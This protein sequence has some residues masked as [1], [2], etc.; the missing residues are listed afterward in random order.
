MCGSPGM[1]SGLG[2]LERESRAESRCHSHEAPDSNVCARLLTHAF[3]S[4]SW[5]RISSGLENLVTR[6]SHSD[7]RG[8]DHQGHND[9]LSSGLDSPWSLFPIKQ[10][11]EVEAFF[12]S[13]EDVTSFLSFLFLS[14]SVLKIATFW[15][16]SKYSALQGLQ[17]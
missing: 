17:R 7:P 6:Q 5:I 3:T 15:V 12:S 1:I 2:S 9:S 16:C 14:G 4:R 11:V 13:L 8:P 10:R